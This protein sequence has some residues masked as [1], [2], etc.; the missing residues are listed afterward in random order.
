MNRLF[1]TKTGKIVLSVIWGLGIAALFFKVCGNGG[2]FVVN[3]PINPQIEHNIY[4][5]KN[6]CFGGKCSSTSLPTTQFHP[7]ICEQPLINRH[8]SNDWY[9]HRMPQNCGDAR[10]STEPRCYKSNPT[11]SIF[12]APSSQIYYPYN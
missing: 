1:N 4:E 2:C 6:E 3:T 12:R 10:H 7:S 8:P 5:F 11:D 9:K